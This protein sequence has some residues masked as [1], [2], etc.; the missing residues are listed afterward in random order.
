[1]SGKTRWLLAAIAA[2][3]AFLVIAQSAMASK[4]PPPNV[5]V[6]Q[7]GTQVASVD[8]SGASAD[9]KAS[10]K[11]GDAN[12]GKGG[13]GGDVNN[14]NSTNGGSADNCSS[15]SGGSGCSATGGNPSADGN[16]ITKSDFSGLS[17]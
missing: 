8:Q 7:T 3:G 6:D 2:F 17:E 10:S 16:I 5:T 1:M 9:S 12:G 13:K 11:G 15:N 14:S 4:P